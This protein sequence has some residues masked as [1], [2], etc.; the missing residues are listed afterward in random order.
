[1]LI[2]RK[3]DKYWRLGFS[4]DDSGTRSTGRY[5]GGITFSLD[6]PFSLSDLLYVSATHNFPHYGVRAVKTTRPITLCLSVTGSFPSPP[7]ITI[8]IRR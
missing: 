1:M 8:T 6:N 2:T 5:L 7:V 4:L 3:Q